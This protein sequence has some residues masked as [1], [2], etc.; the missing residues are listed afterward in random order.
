MTILI[1]GANGTVSSAV[2]HSLATDEDV[3][4][5]VRDPKRAPRLPGARVVVGD[6]DEPASL[7]EAFAG[8]D[9]L[10]LLTAMGPQAPHASMNAVHAAKQA[11][12]GH[13]VRLSAIGAGYDAPT[14]NGRLHALSDHELIASGLSW[15]I[16]RPHFFMQNLLGSVNG[17]TFYGFLGEG[18]LGL[19][20]VRDI[21]DAAAAILANPAPHAGK[22]Y[23]L[24][25]PESITL[26]EAAA[27]AGDALDTPVS[28]HSLTPEQAYEVF[29]GAGMTPWMAAV[30]NEYGAAYAGGWGDFTTPAVPELTGH[31]ARDFAQFAKDHAGALRGQA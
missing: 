4:V 2:L 15:T 28:Y 7:T 5:L 1:T 23:T 13:V 18:R 6:L 30:T 8:V 14:R 25:G 26:H 29:L 17:D 24:T 11:G 10:W 31:R 27:A 9:T 21:G 22:I 20:D 3:R 19:I 16:L 12:I